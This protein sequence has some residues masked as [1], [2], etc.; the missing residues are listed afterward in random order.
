MTCPIGP[1]T[2][3]ERT[4]RSLQIWHY[5]RMAALEAEYV[6]VWHK[7][8]LGFVCIAATALAGGAMWTAALM[9]ISP[10]AAVAFIPFVALGSFAIRYARKSHRDYLT[11]MA[12]RDCY[13][14]RA[15]ELEEAA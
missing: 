9:T 14:A 7:H 5:R 4:F 1:I 13:T 6:P 12:E 8:K 10:F 2:D 15:D 3:D 11:G